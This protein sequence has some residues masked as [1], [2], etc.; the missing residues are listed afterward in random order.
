MPD[1][2]AENLRRLAPAEIEQLAFGVRYELQLKLMD[3]IGAVIDEILRADGTPFGPDTFPLTD[4][5]P[6]QHRLLN[7]ETGTWLLI[8]AQDTIL[9]LPMKTKNESQVD[10]LAGDFQEYV[11]KPL[12]EI[13]GVKHIARYGVLFRFTEQE[14]ASLENP[15]I[16]RYLSPEFPNAN[17]LV[18]HFTRRLPVEEALAMKRVND[19][20]NAIYSVGQSE[21]GK[22]QVSIDYQEYFDPLLD[23]GEWNARPF[24]AFV[25]RGTEYVHGEFQ[26]WFQKFAAVS[27]VA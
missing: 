5:N 8:N 14:A 3:K 27:E 15:P 24:T 11:L 26:R 17:S 25:E 22:V 1:R 20:R 10:E 18:M 13:G 4:A 6:Y 9:Q 16:K 12:R 21:S 7:N 23:A 19:F 2:S